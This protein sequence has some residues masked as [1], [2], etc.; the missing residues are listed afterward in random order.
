MLDCLFQNLNNNQIYFFVIRK[1]AILSEGAI[2]AGE[3]EKIE[4]KRM[5]GF[6]QIV[7]VR[8]LLWNLLHLSE[9]L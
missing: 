6:R 3:R 7:E 2:S 8:L 4:I 1:E 5:G 9:E